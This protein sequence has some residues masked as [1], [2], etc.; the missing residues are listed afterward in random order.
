MRGVAVVDLVTKAAHRIDMIRT[1]VYR[2]ERNAPHVQHATDDLPNAT[3]TGDDDGC[4]GIVDAVKRR[5]LFVAGEPRRQHFV[6]ENPRER[7]KH[8]GQHDDDREHL[9]FL[10]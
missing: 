8:H 1:R 9:I 2:C 3:K 7:R 10:R 5:W 6:V 4:S